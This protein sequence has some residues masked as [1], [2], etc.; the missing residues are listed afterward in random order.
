M[1]YTGGYKGAGRILKLKN[2]TLCGIFICVCVV[3]LTGCT[4][5]YDYATDEPFII[6]SWS[7][8]G[9]GDFRKMYN[10]Q[11]SINQDGKIVLYTTGN[12][13][14]EMGDNIP[15]YEMELDDGEV[16]E[17]KEYI[18]E[19]EFRKLPGDVSTPS[20]DGSFSYITVR[21]ADETKKVVGLNPDQT[22]FRNI[23]Q[24]VFD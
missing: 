20:E 11:I 24:Y 21:F 19:Q 17:V 7:P 8:A 3:L 9:P 15:N 16:D 18:K 6:A 5:K 10:E 23:H 1:I 2:K 14:L 22:Q 4:E 12:D 13:S